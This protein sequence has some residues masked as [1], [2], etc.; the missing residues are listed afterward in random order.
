MEQRNY[1]DE[2]NEIK[3]LTDLVAYYNANE[4]LWK[5]FASE[6]TRRKQEIQEELNNKWE[7]RQK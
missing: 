6:C 5:E 4:W 1:V 2:I 3:T 7:Y